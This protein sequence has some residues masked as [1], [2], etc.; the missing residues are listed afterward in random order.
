MN[1]TQHNKTTDLRISSWC[2]FGMAPKRKAKG[3]A[4]EETF[5]IQE[6]FYVVLEMHT[7]K[8]NSGHNR[9]TVH[10]LFRD[11]NKAQERLDEAV[12]EYPLEWSISGPVPTRDLSEYT[13]VVDIPYYDGVRSVFKVIE[14]QLE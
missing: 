9:P 10:G 1:G 12:K 8:V 14:A 6:K 2:R 4:A 7:E 11:H 3:A 13:K 5:S